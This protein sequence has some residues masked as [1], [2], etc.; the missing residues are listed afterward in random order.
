MAG[1]PQGNIDQPPVKQAPP[2]PTPT[3]V[4]ATPTPV[5]TETAVVILDPDYDGDGYPASVDCNDKDPKV[6]PAALEDPQDGI[7]NNCNGDLFK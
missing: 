4:P 1:T 5:P 6:N 2:L 7:D 3:T